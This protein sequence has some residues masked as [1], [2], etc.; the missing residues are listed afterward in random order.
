MN[1]S[2]ATN[3]RELLN[4]PQFVISFVI[5]VFIAWLTLLGPE[6]TEW[7]PWQVD[8]RKR[9]CPPS[10]E[11]WLGCD[12]F[13]RDLFS[14][15]AHGGRVSL[16]VSTASMAFASLAGIC[17]GLLAGYFRGVLEVLIMR[18]VDI[19]LSFPPMLMA[20]FLVSLTGPSITNLIFV[21][22]VLYVPRFARIAHSSTL[23]VSESPH[24]ESARAIGA[25]VWFILARHVLP[26]ILAPL[27]V[28][29]SVGLGSAILIES[30]LSFLGLG[31]PPPE[32]SWGRMISKA[33][34][35]LSLSPYGVLWP[36]IVI[37]A[38]VLAFNLL[39]DVLRD[40]MDPRL[41]GQETRR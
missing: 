19:L 38:T 24:I 23:V 16:L 26:N 22:G 5:L 7:D 10:L 21:I 41:R 31:P 6:I 29:F 9:F 20:I 14:N 15:I 34:R 28:Q 30:G 11:H 8:G 12:E 18:G 4:T 37:S 35:F 1:R 25:P 3:L 40:R 27:I 36:S 2:A 13:G 33:R 39:G 32:A 17:L